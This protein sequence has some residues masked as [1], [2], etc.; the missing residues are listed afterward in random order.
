MKELEIR[1]VVNK[2]RRS[3][4]IRKHN[5]FRTSCSLEQKF[6]TDNVAMNFFLEN[7]GSKHSQRLHAATEG[8]R[9]PSV[10]R[11]DECSERVTWLSL[12]CISQ[13]KWW[14]RA[15]YEGRRRNIC[16]FSFNF[17]EIAFH[18]FARMCGGIPC[19]SRANLP[20]SIY[21]T[22]HRKWLLSNFFPTSLRDERMLP[23]FSS[24][25][26]FRLLEFPLSGHL[27]LSLFLLLILLLL[28]SWLK[29]NGCK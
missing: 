5:L 20:C 4:W 11:G 8:S 3:N 6:K 29:M 22:F 9:F 25:S 24:S 26:S 28:G 23:S 17:F 2:Y 10:E 15:R 18:P 14:F 7:C 27:V 13:P 12:S 1:K 21:S 19:L 16:C